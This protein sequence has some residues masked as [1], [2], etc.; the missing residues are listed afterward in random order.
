MLFGFPVRIA[1][2][3][4]I[5]SLVFGW[6]LVVGMDS[7]GN[8]GAFGDATSPGVLPLLLLWMACMVVSITIHEL[9]HAF[10]FRYYG[11]EASIVL[12]HFGGL[13]IPTAARFDRGVGGDRISGGMGMPRLNEWAELWIAL[14]GPLFQLISAVVLVLVM[15]LA[16]QS[17]AAF[18]M[19]PPPLDRLTEMVGGEPV[20][21]FGLF[22]LLT[23]YLFP[24]ILWALLNL[25]PVYP[26]DGGRIMRSMVLLFGGRSDTW[27]WISM[28][29]AGVVALLGFRLGQPFLGIMFLSLAMGN[30][31]MLNSPYR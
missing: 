10:A 11:M 20:R 5:G 3:F 28:A 6:G 9:G 18:Q 8:S 22:A 26:L 2:T 17:V 4:W 1:W 14:A 24:S 27:M 25:V 31:Q 30:Y 12:Y 16:D 29:S 7:L 13:A 15:R 19:M 23:F 21:S